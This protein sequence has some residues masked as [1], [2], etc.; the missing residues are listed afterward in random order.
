MPNLHHKLLFADQLRALAIISVLISHYCGI[1]WFDSSIYSYINATPYKLD[2]IVPDIIK[3]INNIGI[4]YFFAWP[5]FGVDLFFLIS[6]FLIPI[7]L[8]KYNRSQFFIQRLLRIYPTYIVGFSITISMLLFSSYYFGNSFPYSFSEVLIHSIVGLRDIAN[9][10]DIDKII[11]TLEVEVKFY[12]LGMIFLPLFRKSSLLVFLIPISIF[13]I[14]LTISLLYSWHTPYPISLIIYMF[15]GTLFHYHLKK[16]ITSL[17]AF[18]MS[19]ILFSLYVYL[20]YTIALPIYGFEYIKIVSISGLYALVLFTISYILRNKFI[21]NRYLSFV[22]K[23][24]YPFY[25]IH[26][27]SGYIMIMILIKN[28]IP[29]LLSMLIAMIVISLMAYILHIYVEKPSIILGKKINKYLSINF[30]R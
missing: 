23:I 10:P 7:S 4:P 29:A 16:K 8:Q 24:S 25:I 19:I 21:Y 30:M 17:T 5:P 22:A 28:N 15:I 26:G 1:F 6:G 2:V 11:W 20:F 13:T 12:I 14:T 27:I 3:S 9:S 18:I